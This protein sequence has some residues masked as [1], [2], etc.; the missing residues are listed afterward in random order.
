M[1]DTNMFL[2]KI[3]KQKWNDLISNSIKIKNI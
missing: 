1:K 2:H 3:N